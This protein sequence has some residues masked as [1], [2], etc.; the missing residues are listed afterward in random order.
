MI[1]AGWL[2]CTGW[3]HGSDSAALLT[4]LSIGFFVGFVISYPA[5]YI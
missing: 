1:V 4:V 3:A 2:A 5:Y